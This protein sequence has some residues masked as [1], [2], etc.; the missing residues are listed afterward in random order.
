MSRWWYVRSAAAQVRRVVRSCACCRRGF[1]IPAANQDYIDTAETHPGVI[2]SVGED[3]VD[4]AQ[5]DDRDQVTPPT[6]R[7]RCRPDRESGTAGHL[8]TRRS[9]R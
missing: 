1:G 3:D 5:R 7:A 8:G 6:R 4:V 2:T 9:A